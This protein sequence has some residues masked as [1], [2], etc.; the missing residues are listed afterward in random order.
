[1][2]NSKANSFNFTGLRPFGEKF[3]DMFDHFD[4]LTA[5]LPSMT[6]NN[7]PPRDIVE[8]GSFII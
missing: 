3:D 7:Y 5:Q 2:T 1:M 8:T 6:A 4:I